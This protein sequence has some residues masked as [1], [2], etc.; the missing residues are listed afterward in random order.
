MVC[1]IL[2]HCLFLSLQ[3]FSCLL[4]ILLAQVTAAILIYL[5]RDSVSARSYVA[6]I[7]VHSKRKM[8]SFT[9]PH[10]VLKLYDV[11]GTQDN[12][13]LWANHLL[14]PGIK[15][16]FEGKT[17][18]ACIHVK[19]FWKSWDQISM[20]SICQ[21]DF[22]VK[23]LFRFLEQLEKRSRIRGWTWIYTAPYC[24]YQKV[25]AFEDGCCW[26]DLHHDD[27][28]EKNNHMLDTGWGRTHTNTSSAPS[29]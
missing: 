27:P 3:Y 22:I 8:W 14:K 2:I 1:D 17:L 15:T 6:T 24:I 16:K 18:R 26:R 5:Q 28:W 21:L 23:V 25:H 29:T 13:H 4:L 10:I 11:C 9:P 7:I 12:F 20:C 19:M